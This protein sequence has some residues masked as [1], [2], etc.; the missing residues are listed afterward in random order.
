[1]SKARVLLESLRNIAVDSESRKKITEKVSLDSNQANAIVA[2]FHKAGFK[3]VT[4]VS[5]SDGHV[6]MDYLWDVHGRHCGIVFDNAGFMLACHNEA[7]ACLGLDSARK[8]QKEVNEM[9]AI[10]EAIGKIAP[11]LV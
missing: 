5:R 4:A 11:E 6:Y 1:M 7:R 3:K 2:V 9:V 8:F 10:L